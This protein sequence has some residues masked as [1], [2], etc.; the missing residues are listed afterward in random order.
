MNMDGNTFIA[1]LQSRA[2]ERVVVNAESSQGTTCACPASRA[3]G[4]CITPQS[5]CAFAWVYAFVG[6]P[7]REQVVARQGVAHVLPM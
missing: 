2:S 3:F 6:R 1:L 7:Q 5:R 4:F